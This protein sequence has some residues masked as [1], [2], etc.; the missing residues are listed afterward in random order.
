MPES[1]CA[2]RTESLIDDL[3]RSN[4]CASAVFGH[5]YS[6]SAKGLAPALLSIGSMSPTEQGEGETPKK[7]VMR[8]VPIS[9]VNAAFLSVMPEYEPCHAEPATRRNIT[10]IRLKDAFTEERLQNALE[11]FKLHPLAFQNRNSIAKPYL[12]VQLEMTGI[13]DGGC[14]AGDRDSRQRKRD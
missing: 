12:A 11:Q 4:L 14:L 2:I 5:C 8:I 1:T 6:N 10:R 3:C 9:G 7:A 13:K